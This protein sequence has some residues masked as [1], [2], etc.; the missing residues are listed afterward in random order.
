M[1]DVRKLGGFAHNKLSPGWSSGWGFSLTRQTVVRRRDWLI[2]KKIGSV[3][4]MRRLKLGLTQADLGPDFQKKRVIPR[5][6]AM[7]S[8][9]FV[10]RWK[11][12]G[13]DPPRR[14]SWSWARINSATLSSVCSKVSAE[15]E[16]VAVD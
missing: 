6:L 14:H 3:I 4:R 1:G 8:A 7:T 16:L 12:C 11:I 15:Q 2:D 10:K 5:A 13:R 9:G